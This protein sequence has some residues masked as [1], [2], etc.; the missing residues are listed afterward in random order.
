M[1]SRSHILHIHCSFTFQIPP[2]QLDIR[3]PADNYRDKVRYRY[4]PFCAQSSI[5]IVAEVTEKGGSATHSASVVIPLVSNPISASFHES[6]AKVFRPGLPYTFKV[7][8]QYNVCTQ[9]CIYIIHV[10]T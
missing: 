9:M 6:N 2:S 7:Y 10:H 1:F 4:N 3:I 8:R 5:H